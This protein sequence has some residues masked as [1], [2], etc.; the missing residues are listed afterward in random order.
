MDL[1][2]GRLVDLTHPLA[3]GDEAYPGDP[4]VSYE[5]VHRVEEGGY[6]VTLI[7]MGSHVGTHLDAPRHIDDRGLTVERLELAKCIGPARVVDA[8]LSASGAITRANIDLDPAA[9]TGG[10]RILFRTGWAKE[11]RGNRFFSE[12]PDLDLGLARILADRGVVL[13]GLEQPSVH[14]TLHKEVHRTLLD[15]EVVLVEALANL[16][17]LTSKEVFLM[18]LPLPHVGLDGGE[19]RAVAW[20]PRLTE[21]TS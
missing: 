21:I 1:S 3:D 13:V 11:R 19:V 18:C 14:K 17:Q 15:K 9:L 5:T 10:D 4:G 7:K 20:E 8:D 16:D 12:F 6:H 2:N